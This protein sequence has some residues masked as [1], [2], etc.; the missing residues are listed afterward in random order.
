MKRAIISVYDKTGLVEF[1]KELIELDYEIISTGGTY[2]LMKENGIKAIEVSEITGFK[3]ILDGR[4]KTLHPNI[5]AAIL[6]RRDNKN[7]MDTIKNLNIFPID[8]V[9]VNLYPFFEKQRENFCEKDLIEFIDIGGPSL[10]RAA[11]KNFEDV[12]VIV[13]PKDYNNIIQRLKINNID[14]GYRKKL[15]AKV[16]N[17]TSA[18][19]AAISKFLAEDENQEYATFS[20]KLNSTLRY[21]ENPHQKGWIYL[22]T[23]GKGVFNNIEILNGKE[24][25]YNNIKDIDSAVK[26]V[27]SFDLPAITAVKHNIP[28]SVASY[29]EDLNILFD[30]IYN[31]DPISIFGGIIAANREIDQKTAEKLEKIFLE[32]VIAPGFTGKALNILKKKKNLRLI[33]LNAEPED[34]YEFSSVDGG[35]LIQQVDN[36]I[37]NI[38][39]E[40]FKIVT[41]KKPTDRQIKDL[42]F[43]QIVTKFVK[44]N[45]IVTA[46]DG[47]TYGICGGQTNRIWAA[48]NALSRTPEGAILAS[49][50]FFPFSDVVEEAYLHKISAIIQPGGSI[51]DQES[52]DLCNKY[53]IPM[54]FTGVRHF[55]H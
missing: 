51:R 12:L 43:A 49:D 31:A 7:D 26:I 27:F 22:N 41:E 39:S 25:S 52:I 32:V 6:S 30:K 53:G 13:D 23:D 10:L 28:C 42:I 37:D 54:V 35:L 16:F 33:K 55:K 24:L 18:Y 40:N 21:G 48:K 47:V 15:A 1:A 17:L 8:I 9:V 4:V 20:Y 50:G 29:E 46:K 44:S 5:H 19:D 2:N 34:I 38:N 45:A 3:E 36:F 14:H 11:A